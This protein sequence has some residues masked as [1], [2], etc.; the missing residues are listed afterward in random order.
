M[1]STTSQY[2]KALT[3]L[4]IIESAVTELGTTFAAVQQRSA[5]DDAMI[6]AL[7]AAANGLAASATALKTIT[8]TPPQP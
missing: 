7:V 3:A 8:Y 5:V 1:A 2:Q 6:D 4:T